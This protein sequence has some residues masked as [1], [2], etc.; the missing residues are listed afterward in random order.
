MQDESLHEIQL[1]GKQLV[2]LFMAATV[3]AVV[4]FLCGVMVGRGVPQRA[5]IAPVTPEHASLDPT[6]AAQLPPPLGVAS[7]GNTPVAAGETLTYPSRLAE[8]TPA[9]ETLKPLAETAAL[10][11]T[12][13]SAPA[14]VAAAPKPVMPAPK[15]KPAPVPPKPATAAPAPKPAA[16][17]PKPVTPA[18]APAPASAPSLA[19]PSGGGFVVQVA[20]VRTRADAETIAKRLSAKG[21]PT[22]ITTAGANFRVRVGKFGDRKEAEAVAGRLEREE[23]VRQPWI[24]R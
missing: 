23:R 18:P 5:G 11:P 22:F 10:E 6:A 20:A 2:F 16:P 12:A 9:A 13:L 24:T 19:E 3:V 14:P 1:N 4:I 7:T 8:S 17:A 21:Y 15:P